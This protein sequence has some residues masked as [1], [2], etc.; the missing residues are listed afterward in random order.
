MEFDSVAEYLIA[1]SCTADQEISFQMLVVRSV[2]QMVMLFTII[3]SVFLNY[4]ICCAFQNMS[5][6]VVTMFV[7]R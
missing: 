1:F 3:V 7:T 4:I 2:Y 6:D 5:T